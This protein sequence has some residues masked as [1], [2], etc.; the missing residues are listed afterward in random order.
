M[1]KRKPTKTEV[2]RAEKGEIQ[3]GPLGDDGCEDV[4]RV[5][6]S[7]VSIDNLVVEVL[8]ER[9]LKPED[10]NIL[11]GI[12]DGQG[13]LKVSIVMIDKNIDNREGRSHYSEGILPKKFE[14]T[15][16]KKLH[17]IS[18]FPNVPERYENLKSILDDLSIE[19]VNF[20][21]SADIKMCKFKYEQNSP[22]NI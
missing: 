22:I 5:G 3:L 20:S 8:L 16:V 7:A 19:A 17:I 10:V 4:K 14:D 12:D 9:G 13:I 18:A 15:S 6:V 1:M 11:I 2:G 21:I